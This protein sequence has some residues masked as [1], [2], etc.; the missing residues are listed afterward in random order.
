[1]LH[2][3]PWAA[4][5]P[6]TAPHRVAAA[7]TSAG[8]VLVHRHHP[9]RHGRRGPHASFVRWASVDTVDIDTLHPHPA[10]PTPPT[11]V[12]QVPTASTAPSGT[13]LRLG[14][15]TG[16]WVIEAKSGQ[17]SKLRAD[18]EAV[19]GSA[20]TAHRDPVGVPGPTADV[21]GVDAS[22]AAAAGPGAR[23]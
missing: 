15:P 23:R 13:A 18:L 12:Q 2:H 8:M 19:L 20:P 7:F 6:V 11:R 1:M 10:P 4:T 21:T 17:P 22:L 14:T 5:R 3:G 16:T 9:G